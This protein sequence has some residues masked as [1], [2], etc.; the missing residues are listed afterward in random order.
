MALVTAM[1]NSYGA[2]WFDEEWQPEFGGDAW[3][4]V[5]GDYAEMLTEHGPEEAATLGFQENLARF[6][7]G[8]CAIWV[9]ATS[10]G[11]FVV[12]EE[13]S[14]ADSVGFAMA[15]D[16]G[17]G[18]RA[19][20]LWAWALAIP[21]E[22]GNEAA[23]KK[24]VAW[25]TSKDYIEL[26]AETEGWASVPPGARASLYENPDY[27]KVPFAEMTLASINAADP[28]EPTVDEVPYNGVQFVAIPE[29]Q[30][31]GTAVGQRFAK[32]LDGSISAEEA[33]TDAQWVTEKVI[34]RTDRLGK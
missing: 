3:N 32:A 2:R 1:A 17:L 34:E 33:R 30:S 9:D 19:N 28:A 25:A 16:T 27:K 4:N 15:P 23:A 12:D 6:R 11:Q 24:F 13:S 29:F 22:S 8:G 18:K 26:V 14:V 20:W 5:L 10:A 21:K 7:E 31:I